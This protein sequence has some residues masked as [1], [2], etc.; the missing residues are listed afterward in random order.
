MPKEFTFFKKSWL[1]TAAFFS[2]GL[3]ANAQQLSFKIASDNDDAEE[4]V[5]TGSMYFDS[6]DLELTDDGGEQ[7]VGLRFQNVQIPAN[8]IISNA[9][10]QFAQDE[11]KDGNTTTL[12][13]K[14]EKVENSAVFE[15]VN[16][17]LSSRTTTEDSVAWTITEAWAVSNEQSEEQ[18]TPN[19]L[20]LISEVMENT[21]WASGN[22]LTFLITG[23]GN[24]RRTVESFNGAN[25][26][27]LT[28]TLVIE[29]TLRYEVSISD[30]DDDVEQVVGLTGLDLSSSD[31]EIITESNP[32]VIGLRFRNVMLPTAAVIDSA[33]IQFTVDTKETGTVTTIIAGEISAN[34]KVFT[35]G[36]DLMDESNRQFNLSNF[37]LWSVQE[38]GEPGA[39]GVSE[40]T[41]D[42]KGIIQFIVDQRAWVSGNAL[43]LGMIDPHWLDSGNFPTASTG[44]REVESYDGAVGD[45][46]DAG[47][48]PKLV[49]YYKNPE[50]APT[51]SF[52]VST[53]T[54]WKYD[55]SETAL[56]T[57][58]TAESYD[59]ITWKFGATPIGKGEGQ[60]TELTAPAGESPVTAYFRQNIFVE[61]GVSEE[62]D[63]L[64]FRIKA[65]D[66]AIVYL[67][68]VEQFRMNMPEGAVDNTTLATAEVSDE[69]E[70]FVLVTV[71]NLDLIDGLN[72]VAVEVHQASADDEDIDFDMEMRGKPY[73]L[74]NGTFPINKYSAWSYL[75]NGTDQG[76]AWREASFEIGNWPYGNGPLGY[77]NPS[78]TELSYGEDGNNKYITYYFRKTIDLENVN[79]L[80]ESIDFG[81][82]VDDGAVVYVNNQ[83]VFRIN[84]P[85]GE[86]NYLTEASDAIGGSDESR[87]FIFNYETS[88]LPFVAGENIIAVEVHQ[89]RPSSSDLS[90]DLEIREAVEPATPPTVGFACDDVTDSH[91]SCFTTLQPDGQDPLLNVPA[92]HELQVL[93]EEGDVYTFQKANVPTTA[94]GNNDF[95]GYVGKDGSSREGIVSINH[96][97]SP[98]GVSIIDIHFDETTGLWLVD[99]TQGVDFSVVNGTVRNC[100]GGITPWGTVI[101]SEESLPT[102][103]VD[104]DGRMDIGW[105]VEIDPWT[106]EVKDYGN[107]PEKLWQVG[108]ISHENIVVADDSVT[109]YQGEDSGSGNFYKFVADEKTNLSSGTLYVLKLDADIV[110]G[111]PTVKTGTWVEVPN[112]TISD[113]NNTKSLAASLGGTIFDGIEDAE[114]NPV[115][116]QIYFTAK[117]AA[118]TYRF[119]DNGST[120]SDFETF[121]GGKSYLIN[122]GSE[123][124]EEPWGGGNDNLVFDDRGNLYVLQDGGDNYIWLVG[125]DHTQEQ[126]QVSIFARFPSG[127]EPCGMTFTPDYRYA[128]VSVQHPSSS[129]GALTQ[130]DAAGYTATMAKSTTVVI[131]RKEF[132][133][134]DII[135]SVFDKIS[136]E[137]VLSAYPNPSEGNVKVDF[138]LSGTSKVFA[139]LFDMQGKLI[140]TVSDDTYTSGLQ[141]VRLRNLEP[142]VYILNVRINENSYAK[143]ILVK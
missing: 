24:G 95:T 27:D 97:T 123:V 46:S 96:E 65:D 71:D 119:T 47:R 80:P 127:S 56:A 88:E 42:L 15:N 126:P 101:T 114:I 129:N 66:G 31:L 20:P 83:E 100:S 135:T 13:I 25:G 18:R 143:T 10:I 102:S 32:Q 59:D 72:I 28:P 122:D 68:G 63:S 86:I 37:V 117:G 16:Y 98:G 93:L 140:K 26:G 78:A 105:Q 128:F 134:P 4:E 84:M 7:V 132:L 120:I 79:D 67:N 57:D 8:A 74:A 39:S 103:D 110:N 108:R 73:P 82:N 109:A 53:G 142:G 104:S 136:G 125:K 55:Y 121:V 141:S 115:T 30:G 94:G 118:R 138:H 107:G 17:N 40:R 12:T 87:Y 75:D 70:G 9:Y 1:L 133:G 48:A 45:H 5:A 29:Y 112:K 92:S 91:F 111:E 3:W 58:W 50:V 85:E 34:S 52:P 64:I 113:Q 38:M 60:T 2:L 124:R 11:N 116:G 43:T 19:L 44:Q 14:A 49:I 99:E 35:A 106:K 131:S 23:D 130:E 22:A 76:T 36:E 51:G 61:E 137:T 6:S 41:P 77:S 62:Q 69:D 90:F 33:Y 54:I 139:Q 81:L 21:S 89:D